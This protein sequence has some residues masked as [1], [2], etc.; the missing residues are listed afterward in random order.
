MANPNKGI[1]PLAPALSGANNNSKIHG[2][3]GGGPAGQWMN[4]SEGYA[5]GGEAKSAEY[6]EPPSK[7]VM[8][9]ILYG[10]ALGGLT[11]TAKQAPFGYL[12]GG[13]I[14]DT[15]GGIN[16]YTQG[17]ISHNTNDPRS[18]YNPQLPGVSKFADGGAAN[19]NPRTSILSMAVGPWE[20]AFGPGFGVMVN[21]S[22]NNAFHWSHDNLLS[23]PL[24]PANT[25]APLGRAQGGYI[26]ASAMGYA[27]GG[28][29]IADPR[30]GIIEHYES[31]GKNVMNYINDKMHTASGYYQITNQTWRG[32]A[33]DAGVDLSKYPTAISAPKEVQT[34]AANTL[35]AK[36]GDKPW[37]PFNPKLAAALGSNAA[38]L[39][40]NA[41][42]LGS[43]HE[44]PNSQTQQS[45]LSKVLPEEEEQQPPQP[46]VED[47]PD[48]SAMIAPEA[49]QIHGYMNTLRNS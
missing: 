47:T 4:M 39:G 2:Y 23:L 8:D 40:S 37:A 3:A 24:N 13:A 26:E 11:D 28:S 41:A 30:L 34:Q 25:N 48:I 44:V 27:D 20:S 35:L 22:N 45:L 14:W 6:I 21:G 43:N 33:K 18:S 12:G 15:S 17:G 29:I 32:I 10:F 38:A 36:Y 31:G 16:S 42:A 19:D 9:S 1:S 5:D 49:D 46:P 7:S